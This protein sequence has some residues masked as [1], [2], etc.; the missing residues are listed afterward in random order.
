[1]KL[2]GILTSV[3]SSNKPRCR[4]CGKSMREEHCTND[5]CPQLPFQILTNR[6]TGTKPM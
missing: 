3:L 5:W 2:W 4:D 1:M 6:R